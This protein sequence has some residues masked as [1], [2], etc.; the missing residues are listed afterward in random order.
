MTKTRIASTAAVFTFGLAAIGGTVLTIAA[1]A[2]AAPSTSV[3]GGEVHSHGVH[4]RLNPDFAKPIPA[5]L[6][7]DF[8]KP[9]HA[10]LNPD[11]A[12]PNHHKH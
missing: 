2:N 3:S 10:H 6:N 7:P 9:V 4:A 11:F 8:A 1:P 12:K 5:R